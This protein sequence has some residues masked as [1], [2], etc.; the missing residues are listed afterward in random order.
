MID[1]IKKIQINKTQ[2]EYHTNRKEHFIILLLEEESFTLVGFLIASLPHIILVKSI[3]LHP[4][5][6]LVWAKNS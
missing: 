3:C 6:R 5:Q 1:L 4:M 2:A